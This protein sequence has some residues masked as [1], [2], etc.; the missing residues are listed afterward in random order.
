[1]SHANAPLTPVGH[2]LM[3]RKVEAGMLQAHV[4]RQMRLSRGAVSK[5]WNRYV[6]EGEAG[7]VDRSSRPRRCPG[8]TP[9]SVEE[10]ICWLR[11]STRRGPVYLSARTPVPAS[12]G[13]RIRQRNGLNRLS[14]IDGPT[15]RVIRRYERSSP[16][17]L[18]PRHQQGRPD[19]TRGRLKSARPRQPQSQALQAHPGGLHLPTRRHRRPLARRL[20][21]GPRQRDRQNVGEVLAAGPRLVLVKRHGCR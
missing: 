2:L 4:A 3:D 17:E 11:R 16:G 8:R 5:R 12:T 18:A 10:R 20:R 15:G 13:W 9:V 7:L 1:M 14:C 19:P 21:R 6:A